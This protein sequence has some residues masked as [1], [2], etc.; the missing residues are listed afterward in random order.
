VR[1]RPP[2]IRLGD[3]RSSFWRP[4][5]RRQATVQPAAATMQRPVTDWIAHRAHLALAA[6]TPPRSA[7][8]TIA[9]PV[10]WPSCPV[11]LQLALRHTQDAQ[12]IQDVRATGR[13]NH[14]SKPHDA[15][16][17]KSFQ[18]AQLRTR[19]PLSARFTL[20][21]RARE[22]HCKACRS[23]RLTLHPAFLTRSGAPVHRWRVLL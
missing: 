6:I 19:S 20:G 1:F 21:F 14:A 22:V 2:P 11:P 3:R 4:R 5:A 10:P 7:H 8:R 17:P 23:G 13:S 9:P 12:D 18:L 15:R 16:A